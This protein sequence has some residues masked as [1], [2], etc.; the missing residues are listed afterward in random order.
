V[1]TTGTFALIPLALSTGTAEAAEAVPSV[2]WGPITHCESGGNPRATNSSSTASGLFQFL[3]SSWKAYGGG[4]YSARAKDATVAQQFEI[5]DTAFRT[6]GLRPWKASQH[7]WGGKVNTKAPS[8]IP[9]TKSIPVK[10]SVPVKKSIPAPRTP[11]QNLL[12][13]TNLDPADRVIPVSDNGGGEVYTVK[14]GDSLAKIAAG[15]QITWQ[16]VWEAN[17]DRVA[18]PNLLHPGDQLRM[19][20]LP[21]RSPA[22]AADAA[23]SAILGSDVPGGAI[24]L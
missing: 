20:G 4:K 5:A 21:T 14:A 22:A 23:P 6:S 1:I 2:D 15:R 8:K 11:A 19:P 3:D 12:P 10:N 9:G 18:K 13:K 17:K 7:C 16:A 24:S